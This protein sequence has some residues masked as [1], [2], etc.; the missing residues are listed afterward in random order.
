MRLL[1]VHQEVLSFGQRRWYEESL[2][3]QLVSTLVL[4]FKLNSA[5]IRGSLKKIVITN[6]YNC[7]IA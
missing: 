5:E 3:L 6:V 7:K 4:F 1:G 2:Y